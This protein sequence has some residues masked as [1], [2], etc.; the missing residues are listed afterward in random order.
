[1]SYTGKHYNIAK[2]VYAN[3]KTTYPNYSPIGGPIDIGL[4]ITQHII[5]V[6]D[7]EATTIAQDLIDEQILSTQVTVTS[8][9]I[10]DWKNTPVTLIAA[11]GSGKIIDVLSVM[12]KLTFNSIAYTIVGLTALE[13]NQGT[14]VLYSNAAASSIIS[15]GSTKYWKL[16]PAP[17]AAAAT[18][19]NANTA[20]T[21]ACTG[22]APAAGNSTITFDIQYRILTL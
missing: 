10:L 9:Q 18:N 16:A 17:A 12:A 14:A 5:D 22:A 19:V 1:M 4:D 20:I 3:K 13:I 21:S 11:P 7:S 8:A 6:A 2:S 15:S